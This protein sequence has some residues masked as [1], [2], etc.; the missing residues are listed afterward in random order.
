MN[1]SGI[2]GYLFG[3]AVILFAVLLIVEKNILT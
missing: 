1:T 3:G 2:E